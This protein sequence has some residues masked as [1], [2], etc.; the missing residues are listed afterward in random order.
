MEEARAVARAEAV[1][2]EHKVDTVARGAGWVVEVM[3]ATSRTTVAH[4]R[5]HSHRRSCCRVH[6]RNG[7]QTSYPC[8]QLLCASCRLDHQRGSTG[9]HLMSP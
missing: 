9:S 8:Q 4:R 7:G 1:A 5:W 6:T 2:V 3:V